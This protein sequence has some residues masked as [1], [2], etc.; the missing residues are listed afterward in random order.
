MDGIQG[1]WNMY[2]SDTN[3][4]AANCEKW[5][6]KAWDHHK[7][8]DRFFR[9]GKRFIRCICPK[10][11]IV[12]QVYMLWTGRGVPRKYCAGCR[13]LVS[14]YDDA[15]LYEAAVF[16]SGRVKKKERRYEGE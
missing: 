1:E 2:S 10:C 5:S 8:E 12:H 9:T 13:P 11:R 16:V 6:E 7:R 15:A 3:P 4:T 14:G